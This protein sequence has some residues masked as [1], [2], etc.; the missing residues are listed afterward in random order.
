MTEPHLLC[1]DTNG[2]MMK[3]KI[4]LMIAVILLVTTA[5]SLIS[6]NNAAPAKYDFFAMDTHMSIRLY[7]QSAN[8]AAG[9]IEGQPEFLD[10]V[11]SVTDEESDVYRLNHAK[12]ETLSVDNHVAPLIKLS[13]ELCEDLDGY[14]DFTLYPVS[15][16]WGFTTGDYRIPEQA[17]IDELLQKVDCRRIEADTETNS[18]TVPDGMMLDF[19]A[20]AKGYAADYATEILKNTG[21]VSGIVD[22]GGTIIPWGM[23]NG[24]DLWTIG[25]QDPEDPSSYFGILSVT[26]KVIS[27]SGGYERY[28]IGEDGKRYI[29]II[30]PKT[31]YPVDNGILS[32]TVVCESGI[33]ADALSTALFVM[34]T[35]KAA[36]FYQNDT[37]YHFDFLILDEENRLYLTEGIADSFTL[38]NGYDYS[39]TRIEK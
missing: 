1:Y 25:I 21:T 7:G 6:C 8:L 12:G 13:Q 36:E 2:D 11:L 37:K 26:E 5:F 9:G 24:K 33:A 3:K 34:G 38:S 17:E 15:Q 31:G 16:A 19:G 4:L 10:S 32:V 35:E 27:T 30:D 39:V 14:L 29:H 18:V 20:V 28:F 23:K 22:Y